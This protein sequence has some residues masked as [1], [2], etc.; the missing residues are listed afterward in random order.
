MK[1]CKYCGNL[2]PESDFGIAKTT[3]EKIYRRQKCR[4]CYRKT[5]NILKASRRSWIDEYKREH[6]CT[7][8]GILDPRVLEF[9]HPENVRKD[10][11]IADY[12]YRQFGT[13]KLKH[14]I[15]KCIVICANCHRI[16]HA[17][18]RMD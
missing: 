8:C 18:K 7:R 17:E 3:V 10:F 6:G 2:Y 9:H 4:I 11:N 15:A 1:R 5:K 12:Y 16:L 14:E 13:E